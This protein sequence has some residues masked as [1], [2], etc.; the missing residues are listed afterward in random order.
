[1]T[2]LLSKYL[3]ALQECTPLY[4]GRKRPSRLQEA[5]GGVCVVPSS[6][7]FPW[8]WQGTLS[9]EGNSLTCLSFSPSP[10]PSHHTVS[11]ERLSSVSFSLGKNVGL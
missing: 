5:L 2:Q 9:T 6:V 1:M 11:L 3:R 4:W 10:L 7:C 8:P